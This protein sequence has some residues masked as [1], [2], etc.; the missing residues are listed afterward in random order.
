MEYQKHSAGITTIKDL[1][2]VC[3]TCV[4]DC[5][6]K[7][8][9]IAAGQALVIP[10]RCITCGNCVRVCRQGA[11]QPRSSIQSVLKLLESE[12]RC[13]AIVAPSFPAEFS[14]LPYRKVVGAIR[15]LG[16]DLVCE[17]AAGADLVAKAHKELLKDEGSHIASTC[18]AVVSFVQK[19]HPS[20]VDKIAPIASP[21][22]VTA[23]MLRERIGNDLDIVFIGPCIAKKTESQW[24]ETEEA[25]QEAITFAELRRLFDERSVDLDS[26]EAEAFDPPIPGK[27]VLFPVGGG[28]LQTAG[29]SEDLLSS[30]V[31]ATSGKTNFIQAIAEFEQGSLDVKLLEVLCCDGCIMGP[32]MA[33][34]QSI[35]SRRSALRDY[36][37]ERLEET[38]AKHNMDDPTIS[39]IPL[40]ISFNPDDR[41]LPLPSRQ[42]ID[43]VLERMGKTCPED[44]L[45]CGACGY[46]TCREHAVAILKGLAESE[47][48][49]PYTIDRLKLSLDD[50]NVSHRELEEAQQALLNSEKLAS[51]GQLS[52]GIA[53]EINNP[54]GVILLYGKI[55]LDDMGQDEAAREDLEMIIEQA[56]RCKTI[57]AGL[58]NFARKNEVAH[59]SINIS[60]LV[61]RCVRVFQLPENIELVILNEIEHPMVEV[62][63][64]QIVQ[65]LTNLVKNAKEAIVGNGR[66]TIRTYG[67]GAQFR[68]DVSDTGQG[69]PKKVIKK[70]FEPLFTTKQVG[71]GTGLGLAV[72]YG[73]IKMHKGSITVTSNDDPER[74]ETGT[75]FSV[76]L[77][78]FK[79]SLVSRV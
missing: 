64:D 66:I 72:I 49:L 9:R 77:P 67:F 15:A 35:F 53:H 20:L 25:V 69:I 61:N 47:M 16:F 11:K 60:E 22:I 65:V 54:L 14:E 10:E 23:R 7:A 21:M 1:C 3:Y 32:G 51:M 41:R 37:V 78:R 48:C 62:D 27:G 5:P 13:A 39:E 74:G 59:Q 58:L 68:I 57:V 38:E 33:T 56:E 28:M 17:V 42:E 18:P 44:E 50:L 30:D 63:P 31:L 79:E 73:I 12:R 71:K 4:R 6:A 19:Y 34:N 8:I 70:V 76:T 52:A 43:E 75:T 29:I 24:P 55:L 45:D 40:G 2:R 26:V 46:E 36:A